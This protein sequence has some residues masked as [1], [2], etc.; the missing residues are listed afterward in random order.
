MTFRGEQ[1][2][3]PARSGFIWGTVWLAFCSELMPLGLRTWAPDLLLMVL[4]FWGIHQ[5]RRIGLA[6]AFGFGV[7]MDVQAASLLGQHALAYAVC[8]FLAQQARNHLLWHNSGIIQ[9]VYLWPLFMLLQLLLFIP[10]Y[11]HTQVVPPMQ[12]LW[13]PLLQSLLWPLLRLAL[14]LPQMQ[15]R[16]YDQIRRL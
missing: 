12:V 7:L 11:L 10:G 2:L 1:E 3:Q 8:M 16:D 14:L 6:A 4:L 9:A 13:A 15:G 5:P